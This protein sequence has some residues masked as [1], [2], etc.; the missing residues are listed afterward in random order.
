V[1]FLTKSFHT[2]CRYLAL[3]ELQRKQFQDIVDGL[4]KGF[5]EIY[6]KNLKV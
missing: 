5:Q 2:N 3:G 4:K 1:N 6:E